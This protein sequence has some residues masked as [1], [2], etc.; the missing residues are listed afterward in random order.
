MAQAHRL[1]ASE[2]AREISDQPRLN[3]ITTQ[4]ASP[5]GQGFGHVLDPGVEES[6]RPCE[7]PKART[8]KRLD[9]V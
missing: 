3:W 1:E 7:G 6:V 5:P 2:R 4:P 9:L 8:E